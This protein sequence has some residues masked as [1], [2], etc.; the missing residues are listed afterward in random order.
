MED[1]VSIGDYDQN[2]V[3]RKMVAGKSVE[4]AVC[5]IWYSFQ[6]VRCL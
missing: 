2:N 1:T 6:S 4:Y 5:Y 3:V